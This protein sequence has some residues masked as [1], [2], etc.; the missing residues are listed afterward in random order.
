METFIWVLILSV[1][2]ASVNIAIKKEAYDYL[3]SLKEKEE[4]FS[5]VILKMKS[6]KSSLQKIMPYFGSLKDF[7]IK[8]FEKE[9]RKFR[10]SFNR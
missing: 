3:E 8:E 2:M 9:S 10:E 6:Q 7:D 5:D 1:R 4:S